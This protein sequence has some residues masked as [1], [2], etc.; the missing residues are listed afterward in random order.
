MSD[1]ENRIGGYLNAHV[2]MAAALYWTLGV[3][4][5]MGLYAL[6]MTR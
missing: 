5:G 2:G 4:F 6:V 1:L 3:I